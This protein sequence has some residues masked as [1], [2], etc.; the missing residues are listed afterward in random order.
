MKT[1][2]PR[3]ARERLLKCIVWQRYCR[4]AFFRMERACPRAGQ[5]AS[6]EARNGGR[7]MVELLGVASVGTLSVL[8]ASCSR[9]GKA[10]NPMRCSD[11]AGDQPEL[12]GDVERWRGAGLPKN[13]G[14]ADIPICSHNVYYVKFYIGLSRWQSPR[15][16]VVGH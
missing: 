15:S 16:P 6:C 10:V 1:R 3:F 8:A 9:V 7:S 13:R 2:I 14:A 5:L 4:N 12:E 11:A